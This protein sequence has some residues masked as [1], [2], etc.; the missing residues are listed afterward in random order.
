MVVPSLGGS[1]ERDGRPVTMNWNEEV[2][3]TMKVARSMV[4]LP[5]HVL[6]YDAVVARITVLACGG[7]LIA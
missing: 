3:Q 2:I 4:V 5:G 7:S 1:L 6:A